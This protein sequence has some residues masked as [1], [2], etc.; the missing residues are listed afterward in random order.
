MYLNLARVA[1]AFGVVAFGCRIPIRVFAS[2][3]SP[4]YPS[5]IAITSTDIFPR[6]I[7]SDVYDGLFGVAYA[8]SFSGA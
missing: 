5:S 7:G 1:S 8:I 6:L 3:A 2:P 4:A